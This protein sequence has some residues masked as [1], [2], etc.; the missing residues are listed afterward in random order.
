MQLR[1][2]GSARI[3]TD[4]AVSW[5]QGSP[6]CAVSPAW[7]TFRIACRRRLHFSHDCH[8]FGAKVGGPKKSARKHIFRFFDRNHCPRMAHL[9]ALFFEPGNGKVRRW[10]ELRLFVFRCCIDLSENFYWW[11][12]CGVSE[13]LR[14]HPSPRGSYASV[15]TGC[16]H[17]SF[18][19][20]RSVGKRRR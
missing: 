5:N 4:G 14:P 20:S 13:R 18:R 3:N 19:Q 10:M 9:S 2:S 11:W 12:H 17:H 1:F 16:G 7:P 15:V 8:R 6:P